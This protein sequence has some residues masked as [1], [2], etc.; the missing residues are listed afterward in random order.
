MTPPTGNIVMNTPEAGRTAFPAQKKAKTVLIADDSA[1]MRKMLTHTL[2]KLG[3][4]TLTASN[5]NSCQEILN[6]SRIDLLFLDINMP[7]KNGM[8]ILSYIHEHHLELPVVMISGS[9]DIEQALRCLKMGAYE[10]LLKPFG[11]DRVAIT[12]K[13]AL[14]ESELRHNLDLFSTAMMQLPLGVVITDEKGI[15][16]YTNPGFTAITGYSEQETKEQSISILKS[17]KQSE[18]YYRRFWQQISSGKIWQGEF[19][20]RKK[21]GAFYTEH[22]IVSPITDPTQGIT[23]FISIKQDITE[24]KKEQQALAESE[25]RFQELADLLP[26]PIFETDSKGIITYSNNRGLDLF[27]YSED[28]LVKGIHSTELFIPEEREK[29]GNNIRLLLDG[30]PFENN[31]Y[32]GHKKDGTT[33][34]AL[35]YT[36]PVTRAGKTLGIRGIILDISKRKEAEE[37]LREL[38]QTLEE[39]VQ[40]RTRELEITHQQMILQE[41]LASIGQLAAGLA[42][43]INNPVNFVRLNLATLKEDLGDL[44]SILEEYRTVSRQAKAGKLSPDSFAKIDTIE[45]ELDIDAL[46]DELPEIFAESERG[47]ERIGTIIESMRNFSF[48][49]DIDERVL[50]D[51]NKGIRDTLVI[52]RNEY[53]YHANVETLLGKIPQV[54]CNPE[55]LN[56][57]FLNL[58][59][60]S[61]HAIASLKQEEK[62]T[63]TIE[64]GHDNQNVYC[65]I[66]DDGPGIPEEIQ[67][68]IFE[69]FFTTKEP[70]SG[71]GL[72]LSISYDIIVHKHNGQLTVNC[73]PQ[74]GTVFTIA[75]PLEPQ[76]EPEVYETTK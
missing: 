72:G 6:R 70:G 76:T 69:P 67:H 75:L 52:A 68:R 14:Y 53:R 10:Y 11:A 9:D 50:F 63:I 47:F 44:Q 20:N 28:D 5:G 22:C 41:K 17:G 58:I 33:F 36:A 35:V 25:R 31:E 24:R 57:V 59:V 23:Y 18:E 21:N 73:P 37:K 3:Y 1:V 38:N 13:N 48:R 7:G 66:K 61:A 42:H 62:G 54:L 19:I 45:K 30:K 49:H 74:G 26:Q 39:R 29:A 46:I 8:E 71:T 16:K 27:G 60:N 64:T 34:P 32:Q 55:Q 4:T 40:E 12:A 2:Q 15:I 43:E 51:L 65:H 56:Q